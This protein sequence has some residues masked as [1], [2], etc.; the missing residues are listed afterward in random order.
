MPS[1][2]G[3]YA[4]AQ[5]I[6][7]WLPV[8]CLHYEL[9][10]RVHDVELLAVGRPYQWYA[11]RSLF[12]ALCGYRDP[13][14]PR[15]TK[16]ERHTLSTLVKSQVRAQY[17]RAKHLEMEVVARATK[18]L[19]TYASRL[20]VSDILSLSEL[21]DLG[22]PLHAALA[23]TQV[24]LCTEILETQAG[25]RYFIQVL[26][27]KLFDTRRPPTMHKNLAKKTARRA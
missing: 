15:M 19:N 24:E 20:Q 25:E 16:R 14:L 26:G 21:R 22:V 13:F 6:P 1:S 17:N 7:P 8:C 4:P 27:E 18:H 12:S 23:A 10:L 9:R 3:D 11:C 2:C 5:G